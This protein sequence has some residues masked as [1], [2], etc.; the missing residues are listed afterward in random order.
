MRHSQVEK[1]K[2]MIHKLKSM[3][4]VNELENEF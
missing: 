2:M 3:Q 4:A 1:P